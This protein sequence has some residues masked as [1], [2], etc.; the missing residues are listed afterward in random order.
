MLD[1]GAKL[2]ARPGASINQACD[3]WADTKATYRL[4]DNP[5]T[6]AA[7]LLLPHQERTSERIAGEGRVLLVQDTTYLDYSHHPQTAGL[8]SIGTVSQQLKGLVMHTALATTTSGLPLGVVSQECW[9]REAESQALSPEERRKLPI[10]EKE[11]YKWLSGLRT[12]LTFVPTGTQAIGVGDSE[13]D[14]FELFAYAIHTL[15]TD[16]LVRAAQDRSLCNEETGRLWATLSKQPVAGEL[17]VAVAKR[18]D[19]PARTAKVS[20]R[21]AA[22]T[23]KAPQHLRKK[24]DNLPMYAILVQESAPP[25]DVEPLCWLLLTTLPVLCLADAVQCIE[26]YCRRWQ[27]EVY[28][29]V[30][31]S[32]CRVEKAQLATTDRLLPLLTLLS[33]IAWRLFW[34]TFVART[35]PDAPCT[36]ILAHHEWRALYAFTNKTTD[37]PAHPP[38][39]RQAVLWIAQLGGFLAR[40]RDGPPGVTVIWRGWQRLADLSSAWLLFHSH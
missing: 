17:E 37:P 34:L 4:F 22:V 19:K 21:F 18:E 36:T 24:L 13:A 25:T 1:T 20:V 9:V 30:L 35:D 26:W 39:V 38:T 6:T 15:H 7:K 2:A 3:D 5:K 8:G 32:G 27:I 23:L 28:H 11:S 16:L 29:K 12:A 33:I 40:R 14:I 10:E 31:K